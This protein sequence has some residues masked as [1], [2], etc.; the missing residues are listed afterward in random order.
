MSIAF[1]SSALVFWAVA[2]V[3]LNMPKPVDFYWVGAVNVV[4]GA[5]GLRLN[6]GCAVGAGALNC[7]YYWG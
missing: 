2:V 6:I 3:L 4:A 1:V 5:A 7:C